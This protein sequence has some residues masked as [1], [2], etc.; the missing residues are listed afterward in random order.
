MFWCIPVHFNHSYYHRVLPITDDDKHE[1]CSSS[2][3]SGSS[4]SGGSSSSSIEYYL[5][6]IIAV[7]LQDQRTVS[8]KSVSISQY[9]VTD[10]H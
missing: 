6:G 9:M 10:Q 5:G 2:G 3:S 7:L 1:R 8:T 4:S